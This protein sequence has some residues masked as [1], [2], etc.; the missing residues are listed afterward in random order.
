MKRILS[1]ALLTSILIAGCG[2][3]QS[4][5]DKADQQR[6]EDQAKVKTDYDSVAGT[7][8]GI[9]QGGMDNA[10]RQVRFVIDAN[11]VSSVNLGSSEV[12]PV[13]NL[14]GSIFI[15]VDQDCFNN[16]KDATECSKKN[17]GKT[18]TPPPTT[19]PKNDITFNEA[20]YAYSTGHYDSATKLIH[21]EDRKSVVRERVLTDV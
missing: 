9:I 15:Y 11:G 18:S 10:E 20:S 21:L 6:R 1:F 16:S 14:S 13:P 4:A 17:T 12:T 8:I 2:P 5:K 3:E 19:K 7:Y